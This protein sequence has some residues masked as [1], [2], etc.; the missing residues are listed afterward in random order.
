[1]TP[2]RRRAGTARRRG[3]LSERL[4]QERALPHARLAADQ[5]DT[6]RDEAAAQ[7]AVELTDAGGTVHRAGARHRVDRHRCG[8]HR[9]HAR[10]GEGRSTPGAGGHR[11][12][13]GAPGAA[14]GTTPEP[15]GRRRPALAATVNR[16]GL[17]TAHDRTGV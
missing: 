15:A 7:D 10:G 5:R 14:V 8:R 17:H 9:T 4:Q 12:D 1:M 2:P 11:L 6:A 16:P 3:E 13:E